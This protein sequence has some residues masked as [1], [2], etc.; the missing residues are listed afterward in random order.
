VRVLVLSTDF[1]PHRAGGYELHCQM[2]VE[3]LRAHGHEVHVLT[4]AREGGAPDADPH[5]RRTLTRFPVEPRP[6]T[7]REAWRVELR[8]A[9]A[10]ESALHDVRPDV[11]SA[12]RLGELSMSLV[13]RV[14]RAGVALVGM[15]CDPW[16]LTGPQRDPWSRLRAHR[17]AFGAAGRWLFVSEALRRAVAAEVALA[18]TGVVH[19]GVRLDRLALR[20]RRPWA[21]RLL[22]AGRLSPLKGVDTAIR[23][24]AQLPW[25]LL[26]VVGEGPAPYVAGLRELAAE[27][28]CAHRV[29]FR[30]AVAPNAV[31]RAYGSADALLFPVRWAEPFGLVPLEAM[32]CGTPVVATGTGGSAEY[33]RDGANALLAAPDDPAAFAAAVGRL[34]G[35]AALRDR[36]REEGRRTAEAFPEERSSSAIRRELEA[37]ASARDRAHEVEQPVGVAVERD[38]FADRPRAVAEDAGPRFAREQRRE[39][40]E[41][42][43]D[44]A[45]AEVA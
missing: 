16:M 21:G 19:A 1:P 15:V 10:L 36:L 4:S 35:D 26:D 39:L 9:A 31:A 11:V 5:V 22:Y 18:D 40:G 43:E 24:T 14:R 27:L 20:P 6:W 34:A 7:P 33:L 29:T 38:L 32:A 45:G 23:A 28:G 2:A 30:G 44:Q 17:P 12:W 42:V 8:N 13:E 3:H 37:A 25:A 41:V